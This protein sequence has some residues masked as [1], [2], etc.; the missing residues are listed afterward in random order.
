M[1]NER[2][3]QARKEMGYL[4]PRTEHRNVLKTWA[5]FVTVFWG[6]A[7]RSKKEQGEPES[8]R[9]RDKG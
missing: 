6:R 4:H 1:K 2:V 7:K 5:N 8:V 3:I 9:R